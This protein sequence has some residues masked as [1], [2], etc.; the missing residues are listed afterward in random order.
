MQ[1]IIL[2]QDFVFVFVYVSIYFFIEFTVTSSYTCKSLSRKNHV[3]LHDNFREILYSTVN[4][5]IVIPLEPRYDN[6]K[7][8]WDV[9]ILW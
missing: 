2:N 4:M 6:C 1:E 5:N 3:G 7:I 8:K 9:A